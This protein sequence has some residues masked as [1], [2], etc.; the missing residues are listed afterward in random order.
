MKDPIRKYTPQYAKAR[1]WEDIEEHF[2]NLFS[3]A[4]KENIAL[5]INHI[6]TTEVSKRI[7]A[8]T[9]MNKLIISIYNPIEWNR[10]A[11]HIEFDIYTQKWSFKYFPKP[12]EEEEFV[13]QYPLEVGIQKFD[14]FIGMVKW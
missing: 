2:I 13:R 10:E 5:L 3:G 1:P 11:L 4:H 14:Q 8:Y 7:F 6:I 12:N 9:S